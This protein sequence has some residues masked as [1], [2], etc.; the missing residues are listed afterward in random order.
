MLA[1][2]VPAKPRRPVSEIEEKRFREGCLHYVERARIYKQ[3]T[4]E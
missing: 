3:E 2:G 1:M 4:P